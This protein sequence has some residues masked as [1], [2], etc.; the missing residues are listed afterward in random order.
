M[1]LIEPNN[2]TLD[3]YRDAVK[4]HLNYL[5]VAAAIAEVTRLM[6][7]GQRQQQPVNTDMM[8]RL[9]SVCPDT[10]L[11]EAR[12]AAVAYVAGWKQALAA[13]SGEPHE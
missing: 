12:A 1:L 2:A 13:A 8:A 4:Q 10:S 11:G 9:Y 7:T 6:A 3:P 5:L